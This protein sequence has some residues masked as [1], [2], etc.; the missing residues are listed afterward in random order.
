M[1]N[2]FNRNLQPQQSRY[3]FSASGDIFVGEQENK[4]LE[5]QEVEGKI[6]NFSSID[7]VRVNQYNIE[8]HTAL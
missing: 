8:P 3:D 6:D 1:P 5:K 2:W 4:E 7:G